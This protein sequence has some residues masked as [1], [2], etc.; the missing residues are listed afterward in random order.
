MLLPKS[1]LEAE[2]VSYALAS[3]AN[4]VSAN[5]DGD[6][7]EGNAPSD[8]AFVAH[9]HTRTIQ[10][11]KITFAISVVFSIIGF[12][13][14]LASI[15]WIFLDRDKDALAATE[16]LRD[17]RQQLIDKLETVDK[18][19][20]AIRAQIAVVEQSSRE[21]R[22]EQAA[23]ELSMRGILARLHE[24]L[25]LSPENTAGSKDHPEL[26]SNAAN[27][28]EL[29]VLF[30][31][32][33]PA[34]AT[35]SYEQ[36]NTL[37]RDLHEV[38]LLLK[39]HPEQLSSLIQR[40]EELKARVQEG[41][42]D[43][44]TL[45]IQMADDARQLLIAAYNELTIFMTSEPRESP[46]LYESQLASLEQERSQLL[47]SL[48]EADNKIAEENARLAESRSAFNRYS[49]AFVGL[50]TGTIIQSIGA[51]FFVQTNRAR[52]QLSEFFDR[53]RADRR[54]DEAMNLIRTVDDP[55]KQA[56][57]HHA[58]AMELIKNPLPQTGG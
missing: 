55:S 17:T 21:N 5:G 8:V 29:K 1:S 14:I 9:Y 33:T 32:E 12:L 31:R 18:S 54:F 41:V 19:T 44:G 52:R 36:I 7:A 30:G 58:A 23:A 51:L 43:T 25:A 24:S 38:E 50:V 15:L 42:A 57:L 6:Q 35:L 13:V 45:H 20:D 37:N 16:L 34:D 46:F 3:K 26:G 47:G 27:E 56:E 48:T 4:S 11:S 49:E 40:F 10:E 53:L 28:I 39:R 22:R 2:V